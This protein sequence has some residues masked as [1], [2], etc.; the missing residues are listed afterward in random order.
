MRL[1][2]LTSLADGRTTCREY[3]DVRS[4]SADGKGQLHVHDDGG[5]VALLAD[6]GWHAVE[7]ALPPPPQDP[8]DGLYAVTRDGGRPPVG[9][10]QGRGP[11][12]DYAI[13]TGAPEFSVV[14]LEP[15]GG[16]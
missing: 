13:A 14:K 2:V 6:G 15:P 12:A 8:A 9:P 3:R 7:V 16:F 10:F 4:F 11:A 1:R 5:P